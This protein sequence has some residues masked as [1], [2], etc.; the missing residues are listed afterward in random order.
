M[1]IVTNISKMDRFHDPI[2][3]VTIERQVYEFFLGRFTHVSHELEHDTVILVLDGTRCALKIN[4]KKRN[5]VGLAIIPPHGHD[6]IRFGEKNY[7]TVKFHFNRDVTTKVEKFCTTVRTIQWLE[8]RAKALPPIDNKALQEALEYQL[9]TEQV[10]VTCWCDNI[11]DGK[12]IVFYVHPRGKAPADGVLLCIE[13]DRIVPFWNGST[14]RRSP[15]FG[16][17]ETIELALGNR[18]QTMDVA[19]MRNHIKAVEDYTAKVNAF[20]ASKNEVLRT[21]LDI[22]RQADALVKEFQAIK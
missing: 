15:S 5:G 16:F 3:Y 19:S 12:E 13:N 7:P 21:V 1:E 11:F 18:R 22:K 6:H 17:P 10:K 2:K 8:Q 20:D 14:D 4:T 9:G